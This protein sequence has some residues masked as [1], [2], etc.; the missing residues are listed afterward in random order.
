MMAIKWQVFDDFRDLVRGRIG[1]HCIPRPRGWE[2]VVFI[3]RKT[4]FCALA[5]AIPVLL[6]PVWVVLTF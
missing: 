2:L 5:F 3:G 6:H 1:G 4:V